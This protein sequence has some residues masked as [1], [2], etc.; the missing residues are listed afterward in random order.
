MVLDNISRIVPFGGQNPYSA[1]SFK[2]QFVP[3]CQM[4]AF[5]EDVVLVF[6]EGF[7]EAVREF[8]QFSP[9]SL[10]GLPLDILS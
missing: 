4:V 6:D 8:D 2:T 5:L 7:I 9:R 1:P 10:E 3:M